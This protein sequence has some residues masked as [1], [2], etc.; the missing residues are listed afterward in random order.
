MVGTSSATTM[1]RRTTTAT[2]HTL[3]AR[4]EPWADDGRGVAGVAWDVSIMSLKAFDQ[5]RRSRQLRRPRGCNRVR[6][7]QR[8]RRHQRVLGRRRTFDN[9]VRS[10]I[11]SSPAL[12]VAAAGNDEQRHG[13]DT[14]LPGRLRPGQHPGCRRDDQQGRPGQLL[15][16]RGDDG[17]CGGAR[18][19]ISSARSPRLTYSG[20]SL[21]DPGWGDIFYDPFPTQGGW[22]TVDYNYKPW[23]LSSAKPGS[24]SGVPAIANRYYSA[25]EEAYLDL[26]YPIDLSQS[27]AAG[28]LFDLAAS[29][30]PGY[31]FLV[32][33]ASDDGGSTW[34]PIENV[35]YTGSTASVQ[36][37]A[38]NDRFTTAVKIARE[39]YDPAGNKTWPG[40]DSVIVASGDDRA[41]A[42]PLSAAGLCWAYD[43]PLFLVSASST[44]V[45]VKAAI[46][47]IAARNGG[48]VNVIIVGGKVSVPDARYSD[49]ANYVGWGELSKRR[50]AGSDRY[51][52]AAAIAREMRRVK[53]AT[54]KVLVA[55]GADST[56]F[57]DALAL[58]PIAARNGYPIIPVSAT[59]VPSA[60]RSILNEIGP[61]EVIIGGGPATV[62]SSVKSSIK[63]IT[64]VTP[65]Q[66]YGARS[67]L[68]CDHDRD[69][70]RVPRIPL[71]PGGRYRGEAPRCA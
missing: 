30:E 5:H 12:F 52:T 23:K 25:S 38:D 2:V 48:K 47:E 42:D 43:A 68:H 34:D 65:Q 33:I 66:W 63:S 28:I 17:R 16:L 32:P 6:E 51:S 31:D 7:R 29:L 67:L 14:V 8:C 41:A 62:K 54:S 11:A 71:G 58:S 26:K 59:S 70:V 10:A 39:G 13:R 50:V 22:T 37:L 55:N 21:L 57:F 1:C 44:P 24:Y 40:V 15:Q 20:Q 19:W 56:K 61:S 69:E 60:S 3:R 27:S 35:A 46:K 9:A 53:G 64:G 18:A 49:I 45:K 4:S 36:R